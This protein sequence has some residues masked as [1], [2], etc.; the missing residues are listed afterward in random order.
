V[1]RNARF[2]LLKLG[3][4]VSGYEV[5]FYGEMDDAINEGDPTDRL[6][7][8]WDVASEKAVVAAAGALQPIDVT[9]RQAAGASIREIAIPEDIVSE[10]SRD[11]SAALAW[12]L[13]V[14]EEFLSAFAEGYTVTGVTTSGN[15]LL[16]RP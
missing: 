12:R 8:S 9:A 3:I 15:Y 1:R 13:Q 11:R 5:N 2:N 14:R 10:R 4:E 7:A 6:L 16:E